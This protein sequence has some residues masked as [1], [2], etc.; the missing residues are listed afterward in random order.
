[1]GLQCRWSTFAGYCPILAER[2]SRI[3]TSTYSSG[4]LSIP[5]DTI[6][7]IMPNGEPNDCMKFTNLHKKSRQILRQQICHKALFASIQ[8]D[9]DPNQ[10]WLGRIG[11]K[12]GDKFGITNF[13]S[14]LSGW[15]TSFDFRSCQRSYNHLWSRN[16]W[17]IQHQQTTKCLRVEWNVT[18]IMRVR[19]LYWQFCWYLV[20][21]KPTTHRHYRLLRT[22]TS[23]RQLKLISRQ[24]KINWIRLWTRSC[25]QK[26]AI[27]G[28][29]LPQTKYLT[30]ASLIQMQRSDSSTGKEHVTCC[31][32]FW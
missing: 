5:S 6:T 25:C 28:A 10:E 11:A 4:I 9:P 3:C 13:S 24:C 18:H 29:E 1:M 20:H 31:A 23:H 21:S 19:E 30:H 7:L 15:A 22:R 32:L 12:W 2:G 17:W 27:F 8:S 26:T 16:M 14:A